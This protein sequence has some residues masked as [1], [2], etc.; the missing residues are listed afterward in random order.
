MGKAY[1]EM[2]FRRRKYNL[3]SEDI[4]KIYRICKRKVPKLPSFEVQPK[5][6]METDD[7]SEQSVPNAL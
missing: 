4:G 3:D 7:D 6:L 2:S 1:V 5:T